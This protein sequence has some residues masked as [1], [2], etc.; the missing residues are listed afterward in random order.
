M[1]KFQRLPVIWHEQERLHTLD[2]MR[3][4]DNTFRVGLGRRL[5]EFKLTK[6]RVD[7]LIRMIQAKELTAE[8]LAT[9]YCFLCFTMDKAS[10]QWAAF[11]YLGLRELLI[12]I[13]L[14]DPACHG[15]WN[16]AT[17]G[18][19]PSQHLFVVTE[20]SVMANYRKGAWG[21]CPWL[22]STSIAGVEALR[23]IKPRDRLLNKEVPQVRKELGL[24]GRLLQ[25][26][27]GVRPE[28]AG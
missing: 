7:E 15:L 21:N 16:A 18:L 6:K 9:K 26:E 20:K 17:N 25:D 28:Q 10:Q 3:L 14:C 11:L 23:S 27:A 22:H 12:V 8:K 2:W 13:N 1:F 4:L 24:M 19:K 5:S